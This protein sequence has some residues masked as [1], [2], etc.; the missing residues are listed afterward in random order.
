MYVLGL[1]G[2]NHDFSSCLVKDG[3]IQCMI[4]DERLTRVKNCKGLGLDLAKGYSR[5]YCLDYMGIDID[6]IDL[7]VGNDILNPIMH[8][9]LEREVT[10]INHHMAH[11]ASSFYTSPFDK[12]AVIVV[13]AVGSKRTDGENEVYESISFG[14]GNGNKI[15]LIDKI[16]GRNLPGTD[17]IKNSLGIFYSLITDVIGFGEH[18]EGKTMGLSPYGKET[19]YEEFKKHIRYIG[20]GRIEMGEADIAF[21]LSLKDRISSC[22]TAEEANVMKQDFA[23][24]AQKV[25]EEYLLSLSRYVKEV[26]KA[27]YCCF[28]GGVALNS[29]TNYKV[30]QSGLFKNVYIQA[31][32]G[33]NGTSIGS[34]LYGYYSIL[35]NKRK[36]KVS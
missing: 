2:S 31:A 7:I 10:L 9:R 34:A 27:D 30:Y 8:R 6:S 20:N 4:E 25:T 14:Y 35:G 23:Y 26:T 33:D 13:D 15:E 16:E 1:G 21:F 11:A 3:E 22:K 32:S 5:K 19:Y 36:G 18:Q 17:Y 29:I 12:A 24:A 28:A